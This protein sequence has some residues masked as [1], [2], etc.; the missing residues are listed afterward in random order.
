LGPVRFVNVFFDAGVVEG[1]IREAVDGENV[2]VLIFKPCFELVEVIV[3]EKFEG[4]L[5]GEAKANGKFFAGCDA[6]ADGENIGLENVESLSPTF[7]RVDV[8][9]VGEVVAFELHPRF[10]AMVAMVARIY[11]SIAT[12]R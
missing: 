9:A 12:T 2:A 4:G 10:I 1:S 11:L 8:G 5:G 3:F 6:I 7:S